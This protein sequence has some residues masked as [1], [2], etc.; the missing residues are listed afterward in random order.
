MPKVLVLGHRRSGTNY[1]EKCVPCEVLPDWKYRHNM[2]F[3]EADVLMLRFHQFNV[4][5]YGRGLTPKWQEGDWLL[6]CD[7]YIAHAEVLIVLQRDDLFTE[8]VSEYIQQLEDRPKGQSTPEVQ[9][10]VD[11]QVL[12]IERFKRVYANTYAFKRQWQGYI[13]TL[14]KILQ[15]RFYF[16]YTE[17]PNIGELMR[18][19]EKTTGLS[20]L[21]SPF[22]K[23]TP[24]D[25]SVFSGWQEAIEGQ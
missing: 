11:A 20:L 22:P 25:Y 6:L 5:H 8:S 10:F 13:A 9:S 18:P 15:S 16:D 19:V 3:P 14:P 1:F 17:L 21:K 2:V 23:W 4:P 24:L 7:Y 12:N